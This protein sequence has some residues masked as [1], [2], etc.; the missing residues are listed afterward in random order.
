MIQFKPANH[1]ITNVLSLNFNCLPSTNT[2]CNFGSWVQ[3]PLHESYTCSWF[4][5]SGAEPDLPIKSPTKLSSVDVFIK[6]N[7][8]EFKQIRKC[9]WLASKSFK[10]RISFV[11]LL[12]IFWQA[13]AG[14]R[15]CYQTVVS[16]SGQL[17]ILGTKTVYVYTLRMWADVSALVMIHACFW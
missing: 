5:S 2:I 8:L 3:T 6:R 15:A 7:S 4:V 16:H 9:A 17:L 12:Y 11:A 13:F 1:L 14:E 10:D